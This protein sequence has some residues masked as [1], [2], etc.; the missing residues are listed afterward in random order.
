MENFKR[1]GCDAVEQGKM[2]FFKVGDLL[3]RKG[4]A[5]TAACFDSAV[6]AFPGEGDAQVKGEGMGECEK[7]VGFRGD[8]NGASLLSRSRPLRTVAEDQFFAFP[9]NGICLL[10]TSPTMAGR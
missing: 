8:G 1:R 9:S 5:H 6:P 3:W 7:V 4:G 2:F 10:Y